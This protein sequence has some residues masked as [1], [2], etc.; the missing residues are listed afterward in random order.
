M[1]NLCNELELVRA[2][3]VNPEEVEESVNPEEV[4]PEEVEELVNPEEV[5]PE[6]VE[7]CSEAFPNNGSSSLSWY[8][9]YNEELTSTYLHRTVW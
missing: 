7:E 2:G 8:H 3:L 9:L 6:E 1:N 4:N 5:N